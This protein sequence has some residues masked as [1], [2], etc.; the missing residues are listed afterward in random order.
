MSCCRFGDKCEGQRQRPYREE[1]HGRN[2]RTVQRRGIELQV[3]N[4][5]SRRCSD[6]H[7]TCLPR[8]RVC[9]GRNPGHARVRRNGPHHRCMPVTRGTCSCRTSGSSSRR[10]GLRSRVFQPATWTFG[11][12]P[13]HIPDHVGS[14]TMRSRQRSGSRGKPTGNSFSVSCIPLQLRQK[15]SDALT[16]IPCSFPSR[17]VSGELRRDPAISALP[18]TPPASLTS[19]MVMRG[20][21]NKRSA[22]VIP[23]VAQSAGRLQTW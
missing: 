2:V 14:L 16:G 5:R 9:R 17:C 3:Q 15:I 22:A 10:T 11:T 13:T 19:W 23:R 1:T 7:L 21:S 4:H 20:R 12:S 6:G 8:Q 18:W